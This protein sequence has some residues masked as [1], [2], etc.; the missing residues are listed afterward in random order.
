[1]G[2][3][4]VYTVISFLLATCTSRNEKKFLLVSATHSGIDFANNLTETV[5]FNIFNYMYFYN[6][7]GVAA[8]DLNNDGL[9]DLYFTANQLPN[10]LYLN[11]GNFQFEDITSLAGVQGVDGWSTGVT[12]A[13]VNSDG[14]LDIYVSYVGN[15]LDFNGKNQLFINEGP[16]DDGIPRFRDRAIEY[17]LDLSGFSTQAVFFDYDRDGDLDMYM[18][19]HSLH[20]NGTFGKAG[21]LR[22]KTHPTAGDRLLKNDNGRFVDVTAASG[23]YSSALGYGLGIVVSDVNLDGWPDIYVGNDFHENDYL[24]INQHN[25]TFKEQLNDY[26]NHTSRYTMGVDLADIN[27]DA[28][29]DLIAV[30]MLPFEYKKLK[31][32]AAEDPYDVYIF[33]KRFGYNEQYTRNVLQLNNQNGTFSDIALFAGAHATDW[34]WGALFADFDLDGFKDIFISNGILRRSNDLDYI[35]FITVDS[36]QAG[37]AEQLLSKHLRYIEKMPQVKVPNFLFR[38]N[39]DST[40]TDKAAAWGLDKPSYSNGVAYADLDN[41]G[42]LDLVINN[43]N[44]YAGIYENRHRQASKTNPYAGYLQVSFKGNPGNTSGIGAKVLCYT[45][46]TVQMQENMPVRGYQSSVEPRLTFGLGNAKQVDSLLVIWPDGH[47]QKLTRIPANQLI[48]AEQKNATQQ[49]NFD[50]FKHNSKLFAGAA[51]EMQIPFVHRENYLVEFDREALMP[52]MVSAEGPA[53]AVGDVNDD[54]LDDIYLGGARRQQGTL[55]SQTAA[56]TF[57]AIRQNLFM[58]DSIFEDVAA[59]FFDADRDGDLDLLV[60]SGGNEYTGKSKY[61]SPRLYLNNGKG[62]FDTYGNLPELYHTGS[63]AAIADFDKDGDL[64][65][66]LGTRA[67]PWKY[68]VPADSYLLVNDGK[69]NFIDKTSEIAP[70]LTGIGM[71]CDARW[72]DV[73]TDGDD[74]LIVAVEWQAIRIFSNDNG[75]LKMRATKGLDDLTGLWRT[76]SVTDMDGDGDPDI[77]AGNMGLNSKLKATKNEP[78]SLYVNDFDSNETIEQIVTCYVNGTEYPFYTRDEMTKQM[79]SLKKKYLSYQKFANATFR[80]MFP[81]EVIQSATNYRVNTLE[82]IYAENLGNGS[83]RVKPLPRPAQFSVISSFLPFDINGDGKKDF[84]AAGNFYPMNIQMGR[85]DASYGLVILSDSRGNFRAVP[86]AQ[87]GFS[88]QGEVRALRIVESS[89]AKFVLVV[90]NNAAP[91]LFKILSQ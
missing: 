67:I 38:N 48:F 22:Y 45:G 12:M 16:G 7:G 85:Q 82:S 50:V 88:V 57:Q 71:V 9:V 61:R 39:A 25:G 54:G 78:L 58:A 2:R 47:F 6:G 11:K 18:L 20:S 66:F 84:I 41:D 74:D 30:D 68:G 64:D 59:H 27:N 51:D 76:V 62:I 17:G 86:P 19:N 70:S 42:D 56:G 4:F 26:L 52:F 33:K 44:D 73:D 69:G 15:Y 55:F 43:V 83:F 89:S 3:F 1:M 31:A 75:Q 79:P 46:P 40:F 21:D 65:I 91:V 80:E 5:D 37:M 36:I 35:N 81:Q 24:Y 72:A 53:V 29:P 32:S 63:C 23:I 87:S 28:W 49:F 34:S 77:L 14:W 60:V 90:R 10:R 13:D 8:G